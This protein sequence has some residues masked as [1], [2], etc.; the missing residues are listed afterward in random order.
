MLTDRGYKL[1]NQFHVENVR[2]RLR[3]L[4]LADSH[5]AQILLNNDEFAIEGTHV[6]TKDN[7]KV[8]WLCGKIGVNSPTLEKVKTALLEASSSSSTTHTVIFVA[9][10]GAS[11]SAPAKKDVATIPATIELSPKCIAN[12]NHYLTIGSRYFDSSEIQQNITRHE[13]QPKFK[14]LTDIEASNVKRMYVRNCVKIRSPILNQ[15]V[16][17]KGRATSKDVDG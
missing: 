5:Q 12:E 16:W 13:L 2:E 11:V 3:A 6:K 15:Q 8:Y 14:L 7:V 10:E 17:C 4:D 1:I 9:F